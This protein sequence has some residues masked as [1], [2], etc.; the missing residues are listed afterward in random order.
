MNIRGFFAAL[1]DEINKVLNDDGQG[2]RDEE[3]PPSIAL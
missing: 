1:K 2:G 3:L